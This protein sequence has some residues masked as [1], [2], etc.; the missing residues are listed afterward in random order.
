MIYLVLSA[1]QRYLPKIRPLCRQLND[2]LNAEIKPVLVCVDCQPP[3]WLSDLPRIQAVTMTAAQNYGTSESTSAEHGSFLALIPGSKDDLF[4]KAD[5]DM[6]LQRPFDDDEMEW[7]YT[8]PHDA[9]AAAWNA[10]EGDNLLDEAKRLSPRVTIKEIGHRFPDMPDIACG[11]GG[12]WIARRDAYQRL[13]QA[14]MARWSTVC[15]F[16]PHYA[17]QQWLVNYARY[18]AGLDFIE[19]SPV[20]HAQGHYGLPDGVTLSSDGRTAYHLGKPV[21]FRHKLGYIPALAGDY[22]GLIWS[23]YREGPQSYQPVRRV[24]LS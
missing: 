13:Y 6:V 8:F 24:A 3:E 15:A 2:L 14:Y 18:A 4:I 19:L 1:N 5:G 22:S 10:G 17:R 12:M 11:N 9:V 20:V 21:V 23:S 7:L 16:F